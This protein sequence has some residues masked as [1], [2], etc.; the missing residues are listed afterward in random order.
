MNS[1]ETPPVEASRSTLRAS[2]LAV[3]ILPG[4]TAFASAFLLF[5]IQPV[6]GRLLLPQFG[7]SASVWSACMLFFQALLLLGYA[8]SDFISRRLSPRTQGWVHATLLVVGLAFLPAQLRTGFEGVQTPMLRIPLILLASVGLP[9]FLLSTTGPLVQVWYA[10][11][12]GAAP[13]R[14]YALSNLASMLALFSY[15]VL[16]EPALVSRTQLNLWSGA[17]LFFAAIC[18]TLGI[19]AG[20][21]DAVSRPA[22]ETPA[23]RPGVGLKV[24]WVLLAAIPSALLLATTN[25]LCQ[26]VAAIPFLWIVPLVVYLLSLII[27]FDTSSARFRRA[28][29]WILP[30]A[31]V[32]MGYATL[33]GIFSNDPRFL[34][35][36]FSFGLFCAAM[37]FH[38]ELV[39]RKPHPS[40]LTSFYL[41]ISLGGVVGSA[42]I[43][44]V[45]P[46]VL[47]GVFEL[48]ILLAAAAVFLMFL[49]YRR[50]WYTDVIWASAAVA[51]VVFAGA[52]MRLFSVNAVI[53]VRNFYG[54][55]RIVDADGVRTIVHGTISHGAQFQDAARRNQ[56]TLY[57]APG[58][59]AQFALDTL[60]RGPQAVGV[61]GLGAGTVAAYAKPGDRWVFYELNPQ[62]IELARRDFTF[63]NS[64]IETAEGD[65]RLSL[66]RDQRSFDVLLIDAFSGDAIPTHLLTQ[67]AMQLYLQHLKPE[68]ILGMHISNSVLDLAGVTAKLAESSGLS[69]VL[70]HT[71]S[72]DSLRRSEAIWVLMSRSAERLGNI[73]QPLKSPT[74]QRLWTDDYSD[75]FR[76]LKPI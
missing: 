45:A 56:P 12:T 57:Y 60:R 47:R 17:F 31:L 73:G 65:G 2:N 25:H 46:L 64:N 44:W 67:E 24:L 38:S 35:P 51:T 19:I 6:M 40:Y 63:L 22:E 42:T 34:V 23:P 71:P 70:V 54:A 76:C 21:A 68:G 27:C 3:R 52:Q 18:A 53:S 59:G 32:A 43:V 50:N 16:V 29:V 13:Y 39:E 26:N 72:D 15:P 10:R 58:T 41:M 8:Y 4:L 49:Y 20:R 30:V 7:G 5:S 36:L 11:L 33:H 1:V 61:I 28:F 75:L 62:V 37:V 69:A 66:A 14:I 74:G 55:L 9:F 48:P